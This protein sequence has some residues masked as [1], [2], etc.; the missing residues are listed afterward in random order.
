MEVNDSFDI[1]Q[2]LKNQQEYNRNETSNLQN[3]L[4]ESIPMP[5]DD[6]D[7]YTEGSFKY[8]DQP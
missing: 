6:T 8:T 7:I 1:V 4:T 3:L 2:T 5:P